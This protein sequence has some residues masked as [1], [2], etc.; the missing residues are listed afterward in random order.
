M[1]G[2]RPRACAGVVVMRA[3]RLLKRWCWLAAPTPLLVSPL[4]GGRDE[5]GE[6]GRWGGRLRVGAEV[7]ATRAGR[8]LKR[9]CWLAASNP[10]LSL[11]P[12]RGER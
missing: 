9:W 12:G 5:L 11:P 8:L 4:E 3:G 6:V 1:G 2:G 10:P 7:L